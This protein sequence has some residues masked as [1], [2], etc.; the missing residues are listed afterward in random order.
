LPP[1]NLAAAYLIMGQYDKGVA[2]A[3]GAVRLDPTSGYGYG[4]LEFCYMALG[5]FD[6]ANAVFDQALAHG[7]DT[8]PQRIAR[9]LTAF[10]Q[11]D[12]K[13]MGQQL[14]W[15]AGKPDE[16]V[17]LSIQGSVEAFFG[18]PK[19][20]RELY[21][22]VSELTERY[23]LKGLAANEQANMALVE[24][25]LGD[26]T[27]ARTDA[28]SALTASAGWTAQLVAGLALARAGDTA[29]AQAIVDEVSK[30]FP[31]D[32][33]LNAVWL[34]TVRAEIELNHGKP[35]RAVELLRTAASYELGEFTAVLPYT[36]PLY[37]R[38][39]AYL[40][41]RQGAA[42]A[43]EFQEILDHPGIV[44]ALP[45]AALARL[46][47]ARAYALAAE[48]AQGSD[49]QG[50]RAKARTAYQDFLALWK[51]ADPD[52]ALLHEA[53]SEYAKLQ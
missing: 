11:G 41:M 44:G 43:A 4:L 33:L 34:P 13:T 46:G 50:Y 40:Q 10:D 16:A 52:L 17:F 47:L 32:T 1:N 35:D 8:P 22:R 39:E 38:G 42:A 7:I 3:R 23:G 51:D 24:A 53:K 37:V 29:R 19:K 2:E 12:S 14:A 18:R 45:H 30:D 27:L 20:A 49:A 36:Y 9:Y 15:A 25:E 31:A 5:R 6:E 21:R 28:L 48:T 26:S